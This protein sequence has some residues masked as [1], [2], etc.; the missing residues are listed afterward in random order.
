MRSF[1]NFLW[2]V[3]CGLITGLIWFVLGIVWC[4]T[5]IGIPVGTKCFK[6]AGLT[7]FPFKKTVE[8]NFEAR[9]F[10]NA[11]WLVFGGF[12]FAAFEFIIGCILCVTLIGIPFAKQNFKIARFAL[13]PF[14]ATIDKI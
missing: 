2:F 9:P 6:M 1:G 11:L 13:R 14:G 3:P 5:L 12:F 8:C 4:V 10:W 7:F